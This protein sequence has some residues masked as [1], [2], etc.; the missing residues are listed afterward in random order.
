[1]SLLLM[2]YASRG[3]RQGAAPPSYQSLSA[4]YRTWGTPVDTTAR[5][6]IPLA[7]N[8]GYTTADVRVFYDGVE[9]AIHIEELRGRHNNGSGGDGGARAFF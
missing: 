8:H 5:F 2:S 7:P 1:M 4:V 6:T 9:Q 3:V